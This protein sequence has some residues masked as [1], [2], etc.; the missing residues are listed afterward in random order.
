M[1]V[2]PVGHQLHM[3]R[4]APPPHPCQHRPVCTCG[5]V[6]TTFV[7][8]YGDAVADGRRHIAEVSE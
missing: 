5:Q 7:D 4:S 1:A 8:D 3:Q 2:K 6:W